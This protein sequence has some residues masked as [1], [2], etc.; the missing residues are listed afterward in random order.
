M[1]E[2]YQVEWAP[3]AIRDL[4]NILEYVAL[5]DGPERAGRLYARILGRADTLSQFPRRCRVVPEL[6]DIGIT[7]YRELIFPPFRL[8]F[9]IRGRVVSIVGVLDARRDI[10]EILIARALE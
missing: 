8:F 4:D 5:Q 6:R 3:V 10:E 7:D 2:P 1:G 9:R